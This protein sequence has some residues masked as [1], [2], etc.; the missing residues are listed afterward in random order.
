MPE[1]FDH[2]LSDR[3]YAVRLFASLLGAKLTRK[4]VDWAP[5]RS[6]ASSGVL[7]LNPA[8]DIPVLVDGD[9]V[10]TDI[11]A[12]LLHL[13]SAFDLGNAWR[14]NDAEVRRWLDFAAG[15]LSS[16]SRARAVTLFSAE[17]DRE[18]LMRESRATMRVVE[19]HLTDQHVRQQKFVAS[20]QPSLADI[21]IFPA[22]ALSH[23]AG[24]GHE[25]F[26]AIHLW[27]R[28]IRGLPGFISMPGIPDYF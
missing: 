27:Q 13:V 20:A 9:L 22:V 3:C 16:I 10:L 28:R 1:L 26:P 6:P 5:S 4:T 17:G 12:I 11:T 7:P 23:D 14:A 25:D 8:G 18:G 15:P 21:A 24:I 2:I 19:D